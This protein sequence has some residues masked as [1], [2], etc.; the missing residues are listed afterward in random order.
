MKTVLL[1]GG[2]G[3]RLSEESHLR[4]KPMVEIGDYP[5]LW[6]IMKGYTHY[7]YDDF[8]ICCGYK[9]YMIKEYFASYY[10]RHSDLIFDFKDGNFMKTLNHIGEHWR[11]TLVDTGLKTMTGGR[12]KRV[13]DYIQNET[14]LFTYGDGVSDLDINEL[15]RFHKS[16]GKLATLTA[17][18]APQRYGVLHIEAETS[19][20]HSFREK[21]KLDHAW[22]NG[23][24]MVL[25]PRVLDY[26]EGDHT[27]FEQEPLER[28]A[29]EGQL[30]AYKHE[31]FWQ[32]MDTKYDKDNLEHLWNSNSARWKTW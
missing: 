4:P 24:F 14:F 25:E 1:A 22:I 17:V 18:R 5:I 26:I 29:Q 19:Q 2:F 8:I 12:L 23:G 21:N 20:I 27:S 3:T 30:M 32:C 31:G 6:H 16:H 13:R 11:V 15:V 7:G 10:L 28:L 9:G